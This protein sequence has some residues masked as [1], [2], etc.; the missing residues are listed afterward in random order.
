MEN[1]NLKIS[2]TI[3]TYSTIGLQLAAFI[4][5]CIYGGYKLDEYLDNSPIFLIVGS[6]VGMGGGFYNLIRTL[7]DMDR[8]RKEEESEEESENKWS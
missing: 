1:K 5:L 6:F 3:L 8:K 4:L 2:N 7:A